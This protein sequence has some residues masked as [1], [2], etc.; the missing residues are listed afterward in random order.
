MFQVI[1]F[2]L[3]LSYHQ[4]QATEI[5]AQKDFDISKF[6]G[7]WYGIAAQSSCPMFQ[8]MKKDMTL[9]IIVYSLDKD[10]NIKVSIGYKTCQLIF[11]F[12][13]PRP[14]GCQQMD[15]KYDTIANGH[16]KHNSVHGDN[17]VVIVMTDYS[18]FAMEYTKTKHEGDTCVTV[19]LYGRTM[20]MPGNVKHEFE[21]FNKK[22]GLKD[23]IKVFQKGEQCVPHAV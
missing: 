15:A 6:L 19:K 14:K 10:H 23:D 9:P 8:Q 11:L 22:L 17:E 20:D 7:Q 4:C 12:T 13:L 5:T 18:G 1:A 2:L 16:Y 21:E 3:L